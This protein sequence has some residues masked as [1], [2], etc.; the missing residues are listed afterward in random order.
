MIGRTAT[1]IC[2]LA[3][4]GGCGPQQENESAGSNEVI[5]SAETRTGGDEPDT[6]SVVPVDA[7][8]AKRLMKERHDNYER[9]GDAMKL[10]TQQLKA[11]NPDLAK[12]REGADTIATLAPQ[13]PGW[14]PAGTGPDAGKTHAKAEI[15]QRPGDFKAKAQAFEQA[16]TQF[17]NAAAGTDLAAIRAAHAELGK[18]CK[19]CHDLYREKD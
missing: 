10:I 3:L 1:A 15:W 13:V 2:A 9:I 16:A 11:A 6:A 17:R 7:E 14:F 18:S 4:L 12:V 19:A 5:Q 8:T